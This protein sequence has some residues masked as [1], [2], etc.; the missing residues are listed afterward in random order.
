MK[1]LYKNKI[2]K[3]EIDE[4]W[5]WDIR[6]IENIEATNNVVEFLSSKISRLSLYVNKSQIQQVI[7]NLCSNAIDAMSN[8]GKI[9][10]KI[11]KIDNEYEKNVE[12]TVSDTGVGILKEIQKR[13]F[14]QFFTTKEVG[15]GTGLGLSLCYEIIQKHNGTIKFESESGKG[16]KFIIN[17]P[18]N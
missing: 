2:L 6:E 10:V 18:I 12:I 9:T 5:K 17:L 13:M 15:K 1:S 16:T 3:F 7:I 8:G 14:E 11:R 4:G